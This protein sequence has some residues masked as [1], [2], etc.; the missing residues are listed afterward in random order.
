[1]VKAHIKIIF[2]KKKLIFITSNFIFFK[3]SKFTLNLNFQKKII[4]A[5][6]FNIYIYIE[7]RSSTTSWTWPGLTSMD[8]F[9]SRCNFVP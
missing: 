9:V 3:V 1:M 4:L 8:L 5:I 2:L 7:T 6:F